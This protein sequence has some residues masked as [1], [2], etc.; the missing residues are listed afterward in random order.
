M[1]KAVTRL[2]LLQTSAF[3]AVWFSTYFPGLDL[4][5]AVVYLIIVSVEANRLKGFTRSQ[6]LLI[7]VIWQGPAAILSIL[8]MGNFY[9]YAL[10]D[11]ALFLLE[12]WSTPILPLLTPLG[13]VNYF[14]KPL[15]YYI[16]IAMPCLLALYYYIL[17]IMTNCLKT[18]QN[19]KIKHPPDV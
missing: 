12:F 15:Y 18:S 14:N 10:S 11:N 6:I 1:L 9:F 5:L 2:Y 17:G 8:V 3:L 7:T 16:L 19:V 13:Y 4:L